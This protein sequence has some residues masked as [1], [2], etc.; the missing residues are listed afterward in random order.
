MAM[1]MGLNLLPFTDQSEWTTRAVAFG[2][3]RRGMWGRVMLCAGHPLAG[4]VP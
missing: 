3:M 4:K 2:W 1:G